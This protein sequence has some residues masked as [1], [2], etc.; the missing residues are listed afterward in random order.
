MTTS[1]VRTARFS[2]FSRAVCR[3]RETS[4]ARPS[5]SATK[6]S[7]AMNVESGGASEARSSPLPTLRISQLNTSWI[8]FCWWYSGCSSSRRSLERASE[9]DGSSGGSGSRPTRAT[10]ATRGGVTRP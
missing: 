9:P 1:S 3:A 5:A 8:R 2:S 7:I 10:R 6:T 4:Q